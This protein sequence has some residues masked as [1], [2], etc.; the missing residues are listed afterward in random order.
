MGS[1]PSSSVSSLITDMM[2]SGN[3]AGQPSQ[4][5]GSLQIKS[6]YKRYPVNSQRRADMIQ[7]WQ[8]CGLEDY[9]GEIFEPA[10]LGDYFLTQPCF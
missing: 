6:K 3:L 9:Y 1:I 4:R 10:N 2:F 5:Y 7:D 8:I